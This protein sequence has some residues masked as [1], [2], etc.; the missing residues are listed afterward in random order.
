MLLKMPYN[1]K[2]LLD[3]DVSLSIDDKPLITHAC[4]TL[5]QGDKIALIG[6]SGSGKSLLLHALA[7]LLPVSGHIHYQG[8]PTAQI[9]PAQYRSEVALISQNPN[10]V[11]GTVLENLQLP[12]H[13]KQHQ[14]QTFNKAFHIRQ[15]TALGQS[16]DL[17]DK[18]SEI[19]SGGQR[20]L[21]NVLRTLQLSPKVLLLDEPTS[22]LDPQTSDQLIELILTWQT[23]ETAFIWVT[24]THEQIGKL[25]AKVW[26]MDKGVLNTNATKGQQRDSL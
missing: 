5:H 23:A 4:G 22:A 21:I 9:L 1:S 20:Q 13:F 18:D 2:V 11:T 26:H 24:H 12:Y 17:L 25:G 7:D 14:N 19:L 15:L 16:A 10:L 6:Q 8:T 3:F